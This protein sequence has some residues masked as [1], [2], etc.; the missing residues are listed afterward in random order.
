MPRLK[1]WIDRA[2]DAAESRLP[3]EVIDAGRKLRDTVVERTP[4]RVRDV[5]EQ[6]AGAPEDG[7]PVPDEGSEEDPDDS[8]VII[9]ATLEEADSVK[10]IREV[11]V[12]NDIHVRE[13]DLAAQ[14]KMARQ[15]AQK[16]N[17]FVPP[18]VFIGGRFW[19]AEFDIITLEAEGDLHKVVEGR[20]DEI[21]DQAK[22]IGHVHESFS[23]ALT[24]ENIIDRLK[25][26]HILCIDE[27]DCWFEPDKDGGRLFYQGAPHGGDELDTIAAEIQR[28]AEADE[29]DAQ[30]RFEPEV[31]LAGS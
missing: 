28:A 4:D 26:G 9:Y 14:P 31:N 7:A 25:Q 30:W 11:F 22:R 13:V 6:Y 2:R 21:G 3:E 20:L 23:D 24:V 15:I 29:I 18:Y 19:G 16:T 17:V 5:I 8:A 12:R 27:L 1:K 10:R